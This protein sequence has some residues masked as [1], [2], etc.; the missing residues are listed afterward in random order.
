MVE[1]LLIV[2]QAHCDRYEQVFQRHFRDP[3]WVPRIINRVPRIRQNYHRVPR[4]RE[5]RV[6][7]IRE[8]GSYRPIPVPNIFLKKALL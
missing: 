6:L 5:N 3:I 4:I 7:R 1:N 2:L 8:N